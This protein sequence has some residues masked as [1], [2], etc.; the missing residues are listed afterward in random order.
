MKIEVQELEQLGYVE[1]EKLSHQELLPFVKLY[2]KKK[3][4]SKLLY[5]VFNGLGGIML[6]IV[7]ELYKSQFKFEDALSNFAYGIGIAFLL[8]PLHEWI[9]ALAYKSQGA[10]D[11]SYDANFKKFYFM[12]LANGFV[13]NKKEFKV[14][15]LAPFVTISL[16]L[17]LLTFILPPVWKITMAGIYITHTACCGGDFALLSYFDFNKDKNIV[18]YDDAENRIS[19][20]LELPK[21]STT[22]TEQLNLD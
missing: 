21:T 2:L 3:T 4:F 10:K 6:F 11:T 22:K 19:Y 18:T 20:F 5:N 13:A 7:Y 9:H 1:I 12:A 15:A 16:A 14:I 17:V 8:I